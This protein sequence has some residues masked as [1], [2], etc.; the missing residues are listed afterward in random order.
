[1]R[2]YTT[3]RIRLRETREVLT[4]NNNDPF[5]D[6]VRHQIERM[7]SNS[8]H[9]EDALEHDPYTTP[10]PTQ[11]SAAGKVREMMARIGR[12]AMKRRRWS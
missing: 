1:M 4:I 7:N 12:L 11:R 2:P 3:L 10:P 9:F 8:H 6:E 5:L